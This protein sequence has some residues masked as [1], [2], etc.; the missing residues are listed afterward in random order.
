M[1]VEGI[2][3]KIILRH[4]EISRNEIMERLDRQRKR[5]GGLISDES[6]MRMIAAG[7]DVPVQANGVESFSLSSRDL[8]PGLNDVTIVGRVVAVFP[9]KTFEGSRSG[10]LASLLVA[11]RSGVL[12][13]VFWNDKTSLLDS[14]EISVGNVIRVCHGYTREGRGSGVE[15]HISEKSEVCT[16]PEDVRVEDYPTIGK[17]TT[18]IKNIDIACVGRKVHLVGMVK[19]VF[20]SSVFERQD[21]SPG[22]VM[23]F[24]LADETGEAAVVVWNEM[25]ETLEKRVA[26]GLEVQ[27]VNAKVKATGGEGWE[28]HVDS[29]T[30]VEVSTHHASSAILKNDAEQSLSDGKFQPPYK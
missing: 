4:P 5:T 15:L 25:A 2:V 1:A 6:L 17:F 29:G 19:E 20:G 14:G 21:W 24:V 30:Y 22:K 23:R 28:V 10:K 13:V 7:L 12:R 18:K 11:D 27:I 3:E 26:K 9:T 8:I 16:N